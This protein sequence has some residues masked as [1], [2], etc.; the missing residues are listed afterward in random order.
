MTININI[1]VDDTS[2][3]DL[4]IRIFKAVR[5][6]SY[7]TKEYMQFISQQKLNRFPSYSLSCLPRGVIQNG[8]RCTLYKNLQFG[9]LEVTWTNSGPRLRWD[10]NKTAG[11]TTHKLNILQWTKIY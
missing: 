8:R 4:V 6:I 10:S 1:F 11:I 3:H 2:T 9:L 7:F 5:Y